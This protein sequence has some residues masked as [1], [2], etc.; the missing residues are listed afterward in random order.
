MYAYLTNVTYGGTWD[1]GYLAGA[2][3]AF[4]PE[5]LKGYRLYCWSTNRAQVASTSNFLFTA[6]GAGQ[7]IGIQYGA[8]D[9]DGAQLVYAQGDDGIAFWL[10]GN[11]KWQS[12]GL[13]DLLGST[14]GGVLG[15]NLGY[16]R[17]QTS[18]NLTNGPS[19]CESYR[20]LNE[21]SA[22]NFTNGFTVYEES[23][24]ALDAA[25]YTFWYLKR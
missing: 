19:W 8:Y 7:I 1:H 22:I 17:G 2:Y 5:A 23:N 11:Q 6:T 4:V 20:W 15:R 16:D 10:N 24:E 14:W 9:A 18:F 12:S 3:N 13:D 21:R 25:S